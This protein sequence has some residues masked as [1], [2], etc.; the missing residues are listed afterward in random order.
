MKYGKLNNIIWPDGV[1]ESMFKSRASCFRSYGLEHLD[2]QARVLRLL[3]AAE[4]T[5]YASNRLR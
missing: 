1:V 2:F 5:D 4:R 3:D